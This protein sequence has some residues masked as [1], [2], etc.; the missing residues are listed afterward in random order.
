MQ[1]GEEAFAQIGDLGFID[2]VRS[3]PV[4][5]HAK[6]E[7]IGMGKGAAGCA[8]LGSA[9]RLTRGGLRH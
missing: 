1:P 2:R 8:S 7:N 4:L 3:N 5:C 9:N 6:S